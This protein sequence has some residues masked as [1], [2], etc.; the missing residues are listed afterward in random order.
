MTAPPTIG[1]GVTRLVVKNF[2]SEPRGLV[3]TAAS[4]PAEVTGADG[5]IDENLLGSR[6]TKRLEA[7][8]GNT[9]CEATFDLPAGTYLLFDPERIG[10]G[11]VAVVTVA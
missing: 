11:M 5:R 2:A 4:S 10:Q 6:L 7:F 8:P 3:V 1:A 9:I